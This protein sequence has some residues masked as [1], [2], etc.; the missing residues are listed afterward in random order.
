MTET[1]RGFRPGWVVTGLTLIGV[2]ILASL[3]TWQVQ[4]QFW[5]K[6]LIESA[7][8]NLTKSPIILPNDPYEIDDL[9]FRFVEVFGTLRYDKA[10]IYGL[11]SRDGEVGA[12]LLVPLERPDGRDLLIDMGWV[13]EPVESLL[14]RFHEP[15]HEQRIHGIIRLDHFAQKPAF[16]PENEAENRRWY[17]KDTGALA[18]ATGLSDLAALTLFRT[19]DERETEPPIAS[20][21]KIEFR[22]NHLGYAITWFGLC[23]ALVGVYIAFGIHR[24][25][26]NTS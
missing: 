15:Q 20:P 3:G 16:K 19:T 9:E 7:E 25:R 2:M 10:Q 23:A 6:G 13:P 8:K 4:R 21:P 18:L 12:R 11:D 5:K 26:E 24:H 22:D 17:W 1:K 14:A